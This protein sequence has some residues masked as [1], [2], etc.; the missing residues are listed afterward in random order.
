VDTA[1]TIVGSTQVDT[2]ALPSGGVFAVTRDTDAGN[3]ATV[4]ATVAVRM[5]AATAIVSRTQVNRRD[6]VVSIARVTRKTSTGN[7]VEANRG[8]SGIRI[9]STIVGRTQ[10]VGAKERTVISTARVTRN[11]SAGHIVLTNSGANCIFV[12]A[13]IV[14][15]A[16]DIGRRESNLRWAI[17]SV[18]ARASETSIANTG[19]IVLTNRGAVCVRI[20]ATVVSLAQGV[21]CA[22]FRRAV[23]AIGARAR[24][25]SLASALHVVLTN[26]STVRIDITATIV[27][28]AQ[29]V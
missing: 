18:V 15:L 27:G 4:G 8:A 11:A 26:S 5:L 6:T 16:Q 28:R 12:T 19:D 13:T 24:K 25:A 7:I 10:G 29:G 14:S 20:T 21:D 23:V 22:S 2:H 17:V 1:A 9:T 3:S